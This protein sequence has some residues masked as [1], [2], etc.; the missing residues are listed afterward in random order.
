MRLVR[1]LSVA[2]LLSSLGFAQ[3]APAGLQTTDMNELTPAQLVEVLTGPGITIANMTIPGA[4]QAAG[5]FTGG[6]ASGLGIDAGVIMSTGDI[7]DAAGPNQTQG[8]SG[9]LGVPGDAQLDAIVAPNRTNDATILEFDFV[10]ASPNFNIR[11]V[12]ASEEYREFVGSQ[13]NDV[14]AFFLNNQNIALIP[15]TNAPVAINSVNH[16][17]NTA[18]YRDNPPNGGPFNIQFDGF[19]AV[20]TAQAVVI[21]GQTYHI[22]LAIADTSDRILDSAVFLAQGGITGAAPTTLVVDPREFS[23]GNSESRT[24]TVTGFQMPLFG[25]PLTLSASGLP[26]DSSVTFSPATIDRQHPTSTVTVHIGPNTLP[27]SHLVVI[28]AANNQGVEIFTTMIVNVDCSPPFLFDLDEFHPRSQPVST[29]STARLTV[30]PSGSG[31]F[32]FQ[33]YFGPRGSTFF[34]IEGATAA[35]FTTPPIFGPTNFWV[36]VSNP[37]GS[38]DS[39]TATITPR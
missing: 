37:C 35:E 39:E 15:G 22:K 6:L 24:A 11:Y 36:R 28:R 4:R 20:L 14:F 33:W 34:P 13:F 30:T 1:F 5:R 16:L 23:M 26:S 38:V 27:N 2:I 19:T 17:Q 3:Q 10:T 8:R 9:T 7:K 18:F 31:P 29:G 12:F 25:D 21:P 32:S